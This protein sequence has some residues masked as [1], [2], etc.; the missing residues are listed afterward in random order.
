MYLKEIK[1]NYEKKE[2][3]NIKKSWNNLSKE[4]KNIHLIKTLI[5]AKA[6]MKKFKFII[7]L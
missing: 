4:E 7:V 1:N 6:Y 2:R 3:K 5:I